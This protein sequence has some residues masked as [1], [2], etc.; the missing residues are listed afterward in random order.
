MA[1]KPPL[2]GE[3]LLYILYDI[4]SVYVS[5]KAI[6][7]LGDALVGLEIELLSWNA[8]PTPFDG[9]PLDL[10]KPAVSGS[11]ISSSSSFLRFYASS[12]LSFLTFF[13]SSIFVSSI[14]TYF[15]I[16]YFSLIGS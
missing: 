15:L 6:D 3:V 14:M 16:S 5:E 4:I 13:L 11:S 8:K 10:F 2:A 1:R 9:L 7:F 12:I